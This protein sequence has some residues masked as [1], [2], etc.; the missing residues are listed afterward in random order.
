[1]HFPAYSAIQDELRN[2]KKLN[3]VCVCLLVRA[4]MRVR[5]RV[6]RGVFWRPRRKADIK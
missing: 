6:A 4:R 3:F 2:D 5:A 1:M